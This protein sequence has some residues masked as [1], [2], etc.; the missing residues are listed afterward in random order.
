MEALKGLTFIFFAIVWAFTFGGLFS[1]GSIMPTL[2]SYGMVYDMLV[3]NFMVVA[4]LGFFG[5]G[6]FLSL[7]GALF[8]LVGAIIL[9]GHGWVMTAPLVCL[10][11]VFFAIARFL[12]QRS[13]QVKAVAGGN[14]ASGE[15]AS[16]QQ[17]AYAAI[18][19]RYAFKDVEGMA[20]LK[21]ELL[22]AGESNKNGI[23]LS[24]DPG[25]GKTFFAEALAGELKLPFL[26]V[27]YGDVASKWINQ[28]TEQ[29]VKV[30]RDA[31]AQAPCVLFLDEIDSLLVDREGAPGSSDETAKTV[32]TLLTEIVNLRDKGVLL[33]AAT[34]FPDKLDRASIREGRFDFKVEVPPPDYEARVALLK[35]GIAKRVT[36]E[37]DVL[38]RVAKRWEGFS[39]AR[40][41]S[42]ADKANEIVRDGK[43]NSVSFELLMDALRKIQGTLGDRLPESAPSLSELTFDHAMMEKLENIAERMIQIDKLE[44]FGGTV[45]RG[46][47]F[48][49][50]PGTGKSLT[51][52]ALAK[53]TRWAFLS[54]SGQELL[55]S[56]EKI[57]SVLKKAADI[58]PCIVFIDEADDVLA[59]RRMSPMS[60]ATTN[61]LISA[62]DGAGGRLK[63]V[64][65]IAA[66]NAPDMID[67]AA[68]RGGRFTEKLEFLIPGTEAVQR[69]V[70]KWMAGCKAKFGHDFTAEAAAEMMEGQS[71][72]NVGE[73][74]Q[75]AVNIAFGRIRSQGAA[76]VGLDDLRKAIWV[77]LG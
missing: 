67:E 28:T 61:K 8:A 37:P 65:F 19:P 14:A 17:T 70:S 31:R 68:L 23:L 20:Q 49:G 27:T 59:D 33:V 51:A 53:S 54:T 42:I 62:M 13:D 38:A 7:H 1:Q 26:A 50:P 6:A 39:V 63:D 36:I 58:R 4:I 2:K 45:P 9:W 16:V 48:A 44:T 46:V 21:T 73:M 43:L 3:F 32:N 10:A 75:G 69:F 52:M 77:V 40:L 56:T 76:T 11:L 25:N 15:V 34:N 72:A 5:R 29:V 66:T 57:D 35:R 41:L 24:G 55:S 71:L 18:R 47:L 64:V 12:K 22:R 74:L 60:K 30:F